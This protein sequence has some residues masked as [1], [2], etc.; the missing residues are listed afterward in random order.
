MKIDDA[1]MM[2]LFYDNIVFDLQ[3]SGGVSVVWYELLR[4]MVRDNSFN[5]R[6]IDNGGV[7]NPYRRKLNI[8]DDA[9]IRID[10]YIPVYRYLP[11]RIKNKTPFIFHSSYYRYC[12]NPNAVNITTVHDF[13][14]EYFR[15]GLAKKLHCWQK[16]QTLRHSQYIVCI[17]E[18]T[19]RDLL[20]FVPDIE[21]D[22]IRIIYNGVSEEYYPLEKNLAENLPFEKGSYVVFVGSRGG[23]KNFDFLKRCMARSKYNFVIVGSA[24]SEEEKQSLEQYVPQKRYCCMGF[25]P[26]KGLNVIYNHA[27]ALVY[28]SAYEGFGIPVIEAQRAGCP[29]IAYNS[30]S[31]PEVIGDTPLLMSELSEK[32]LLDKLELLSDRELM[33][34]V[35][36]DGLENS[37]RFS[38][39]KMCQGYL[40]LYKEAFK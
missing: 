35:R 21:E 6:Y 12:N 1:S 20:K 13:T 8:R 27:A 5:I 2:C 23:Y 40:D 14:Y 26:N 33:K 38:W 3:K 15:K 25:L 32:E 31:I 22:K 29:V 17:S 37:K 39:D 34:E 4:R 18:N 9:V 28:P 24:L 11:V 36:A 16:Y 30:S 10:G 7:I 19:K